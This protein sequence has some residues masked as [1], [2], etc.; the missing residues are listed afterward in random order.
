SDNQVVAE[1]LEKNRRD[2]LWLTVKARTL[3]LA[4]LGLLI[5]TRVPWPESAYYLVFVVAFAL[6]GWMQLYFGR[7]GFQRAAILVLMLDALLL[8]YMM[9][10]PNPW[11]AHEWP[12]ATVYKFSGWRYFFVFLAAA[13]IGHSWRVIL[14]FGAWMALVWLAGA[15]MVAGFGVEMPEITRQLND[16]L[17]SDALARVLDPNRVFWSARVADAVVIALVALIL[18]V[19]AWRRNQLV[20]AQAQLARERSNLSR[21]FA[22]SMVDLMASRDKPFGDIRSQEAVIVFA[23]I[24]GFTQFAERVGP[25][26]AI[27]LLRQFHAEMERLIFL[28]EGTLDKFLGDGVMASFGTPDTRTDDSDRALRCIVDMTGVSLPHGLS[29]V[30]GA[31]RGEVILGDV[32]STRRLEFATIGDTV[33]VAARLESSTRQAGVRALVSDALMADADE[34]GPFEYIGPLDVRGRNEAIKVWSIA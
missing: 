30:V 27:D 8:T 4:I 9:L 24:V 14:V 21:H 23:D 16:T 12:T 5:V 7:I 26:E 32:G 17:E 22:P 28:H 10:A 11:F 19:N 25:R 2:G 13:A 3:I 31:H 15:G 34:K 1:A 33:N 18:A 20:M 29:I 6:V